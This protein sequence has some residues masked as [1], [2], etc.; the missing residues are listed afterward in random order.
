[1]GKTCCFT[2]HRP[3]KFLFKYNEQHPDCI[4][5]KT[6]L[7][8]EIETAIRNGYDYFIT[9]MALGVDMWSAEEVLQLRRI[10]PHIRLEAAIPCLNQERTWPFSSQQRYRNIL[11]QVNTIHYV[12]RETYKP[13]LMLQ[14]DE[15]M[16]DKS[17]LLIAVF[18]G[19]KGGTKH[20]FDYA[21]TK[22]ISI[23]RINP[24]SFEVSYINFER[25]NTQ[26]SLFE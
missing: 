11:N 9:G 19:S 7:R 3:V 4:K 15:Y 26:I 13:Y 23:V 8:Q 22:G 16:V 1:M 6:L 21:L 18:D 5:I 25:I 2:G 17:S 14:R 20:T 12:S 24:I 10:Y